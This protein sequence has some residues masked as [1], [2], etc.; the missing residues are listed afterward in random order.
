VN[1]AGLLSGADVAAAI[2]DDA[3]THWGSRE[4]YL[5]PEVAFND[6]GVMLDDVDIAEVGER[7]GA[8]VR[9]VSSDA[10]GLVCALREL[11]PTVH[12]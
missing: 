11:S 5:V 6:D 12:G 9:L 3:V 8:D 10:A 4:T 2:R 1:V 7:A